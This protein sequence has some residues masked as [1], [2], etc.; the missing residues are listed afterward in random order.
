MN[1]MNIIDKI[2]ENKNFTNIFLISIFLLALL[3][4]VI[5]LLGLRDAKK[6]KNGHTFMD[7]NDLGEYKFYTSA[8]I[9]ELTNDNSFDKWLDEEFEQLDGLNYIKEELKGLKK[10]I[11]TKIIATIMVNPIW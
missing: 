9:K 7:L 11:S 3:F 8:H 6:T 4:I 10:H 1:I 2:Y 5:L